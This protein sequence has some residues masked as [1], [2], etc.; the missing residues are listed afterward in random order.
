MVNPDL[1]LITMV[2][3]SLDAERA[4]TLSEENKSL[5]NTLSML[6]SFMSIEDFVAFVYSSKFVSLIGTD[7]GLQFEIGQYSNHEVIL[8]MVVTNN[9]VVLTNCQN[10]NYLE[11]TECWKKEELLFSLNQWIMRS[12]NP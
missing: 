4:N 5:I 2:I 8:G 12:L 7:I 6:C 1:P 9:S 10:Q 3:K 11:T